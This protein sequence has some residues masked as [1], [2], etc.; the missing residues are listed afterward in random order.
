MNTINSIEIS[1]IAKDVYAERV[2]LD[3][4]GLLVIVF[5]II[6]AGLSMYTWR[7]EHR[8]NELLL[9]YKLLDKRVS[10]YE[11]LLTGRMDINDFEC[12]NKKLI[13]K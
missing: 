7:L 8:M 12:M 3:W 6:T 13:K 5:F 1:K 9:N 2:P 4:K 10:I 11:E